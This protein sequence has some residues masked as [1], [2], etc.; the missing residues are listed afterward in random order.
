MNKFSIYLK[1][2]IAK[3][4]R[5]YSWYSRFV[6]RNKGYLYEMGWFES[7]RRNLVI[8]REGN[9]IPWIT[10][11]CLSFLSERIKD[12]FIVFEFGSGNS[13]LWWAS[14]SRRVVSCEH[15]LDWY[16]FISARVP[17]NV[18]IKYVPLDFGDAY[19]GLIKNYRKVFD[20][21]F[22]D[23]RD[24]VN[25]VRNSINALKSNG[26]LVLDN[27]DLE[28]Y[29]VALNFMREEGFKRIDFIGPGPINTAVWRTSIFYRDI[30][31]LN[32]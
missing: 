28:D 5:H 1:E 30:N 24:R 23:G 10:Y 9:P 12:D 20:I 25:C 29:V 14:R 11:P 21:I 22:I 13:T 2:K 18:E 32:I 3:Q 17:N 8:D 31:V 6:L 19:S 7:F 16:K 26:V 4:F 27:S 15:S